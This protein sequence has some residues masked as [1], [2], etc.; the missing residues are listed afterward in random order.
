MLS[1][2]KTY[3]LTLTV[4]RHAFLWGETLVRIL[5]RREEREISCVNEKDKTYNK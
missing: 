1:L 2:C 4:P 3:Q 5:L